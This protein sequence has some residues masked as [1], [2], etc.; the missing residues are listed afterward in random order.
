MGGAQQ[1]KPKKGRK[2]TFLKKTMAFA[3]GFAVFVVVARWATRQ[4]LGKRKWKK[5]EEIV[6]C[7][8]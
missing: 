2:K 4:E 5:K 8:L 3:I 1:E 7:F 6:V